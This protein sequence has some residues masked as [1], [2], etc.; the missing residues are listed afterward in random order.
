MNRSH[1]EVLI[2][3]SCPVCL[4]SDH[5]SRLFPGPR[6]KTLEVRRRRFLVSRYGSVLQS[7]CEEA[8]KLIRK[9]N[10]FANFVERSVLTATDVS[11]HRPQFARRVQGGANRQPPPALSAIAGE[12]RH[13]NEHGQSNRNDAVGPNRTIACRPREQQDVEQWYEFIRPE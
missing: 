1:H 3:A 2:L 11:D 13:Q 12:P 6:C 7:A 9:G 10:L 5:N 4:C 8:S